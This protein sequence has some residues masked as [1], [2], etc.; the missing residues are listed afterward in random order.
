MEICEYKGKIICAYDVTN[1]NYALNYELKKEWKIAGKNGELRCPE[2]GKEVILRINDPRK[3]VPHF[4]HKIS[5]EKCE[6]INDNI[7]ESERHKR[8]K[9]LLYNYFKAL[10]PNESILINYR[11]N[12][13]RRSD[14]YCEFKDGN[15]LAIEYQRTALDISEWQDRQKAYDELGVNIIWFLDG[16]KPDVINKD[17]QIEVTFFQQIM[18]NELEQLAIHFDVENK[19]FIFSKNMHFKDKYDENYNVDKLFSES[20]KMEDIIIKPNGK[21]ECDFKEKYDNEYIKFKTNH[22]QLSELRRKKQRQLEQIKQKAK[23]LTEQEIR[24]PAFENKKRIINNNTE[25]DYDNTEYKEKYCTTYK[26]YTKT[27]KDA[28]NGNKP[29]INNLISFMINDAGSQD[30]KNITLIFKYLY[31]KG[32]NEIFNIYKNIMES[33]GFEGEIFEK[34]TKSKDLKCPYCNGNLVERNGMYGPF[35]S[36]NNF[37]KCKFRFSL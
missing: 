19:E 10:Y 3:K 26:K 23:L 25:E 28:A 1:I 16:N 31:S 30:Y 5:N 17:K 4:S 14:I 2:C 13:R 6:Y 11:F 33:S 34:N 9:M 36:C 20:Y 27:I 18:L 24:K 29:T 22:E 7:R 12:N 15:K 8:G 32:R 37:P 35:A 21:I